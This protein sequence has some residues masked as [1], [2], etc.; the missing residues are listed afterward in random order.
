M[1]KRSY[2]RMI[3][4]VH[5][6]NVGPLSYPITV[7]RLLPLDQQPN[8]NASLREWFGDQEYGITAITSGIF[9]AFKESEQWKEIGTL[10]IHDWKLSVNDD[11]DIDTNCIVVRNDTN[12]VFEVL[13]KREYIGEIIIG[14]RPVTP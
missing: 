6:I 4:K 3:K 13:F 5:E 9:D 10:S 7:K 8:Y 14:L 11:V 2:Q 12:E 1:K